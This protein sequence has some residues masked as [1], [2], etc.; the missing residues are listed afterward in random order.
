MGPS[1]RMSRHPYGAQDEGRTEILMRI[2]FL[3]AAFWPRTGGVQVFAE[4]LL[5]ALSVRGHDFLVVAEQD[6]SDLPLED[7]YKGI[8][9]VR[10]P[11]TWRKRQ[12][13]DALAG[14]RQRLATLK[15]S[16]KP[17][18]VHTNAVSDIDFFHHTTA[19]VSPC[20][21]LVT[22]HGKWPPVRESLV[23]R[24]LHAADWITGCSSWILEEGRRL[25][26][27]ISS[28]SSVILH[29]IDMPSDVP[30]PLPF[31]PPHLLFIG[32]LSPEK[33]VDV[34]LAALSRLLRDDRSIRLSIAGDGPDRDAL[35]RQ[36][37]KLGVRQ[38]VR[39]L[40]WMAQEDIPAL[41]NAATVVLLPSVQEAFGLVALEAAAM[42]RPVVA[43]R[44]GG[45]P[46]II[47]HGKT[48]LLMETPSAL[49]LAEKVAWLLANPEIASQ[50]GRDARQHALASFNQKASMDAYE[51][52]YSRLVGG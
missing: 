18:L 38:S 40:G 1:R 15:R 17:Q 27:G 24:T 22:L 32:R 44:C 34:A 14:A 10:L 7:S 23:R 31:D 6:A 12:G 21:W 42:A 29:G 39:F 52:L 33:G 13:I 46:E 50:M 19:D 45:I 51:H 3:S 20:P 41:I 48:G 43:T 16:F 35:E 5:E 49:A 28:R 26:P 2:L 11:L 47:V 36:T 4:H 9:V 37:E 8:P 30:T 25:E